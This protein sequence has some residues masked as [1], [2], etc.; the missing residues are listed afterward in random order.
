MYD[1]W[2]EIRR[3]G[4]FDWRMKL[5]FTKIAFSQTRYGLRL[6]RIKALLKIGEK[7]IRLFQTQ[8]CYQ[9]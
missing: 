6:K 8:G 1:Y 3:N 2:E 9:E 5:D 7:M 4:H